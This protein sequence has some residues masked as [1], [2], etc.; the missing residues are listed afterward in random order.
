VE[1]E[2]PGIILAEYP[3]LSDFR[4][5]VTKDLNK[6]V[7]GKGKDEWYYYFHNTISCE[8]G[9]G[10]S[11]DS[12]P[13]PERCARVADLYDSIRAATGKIRAE[14]T[15][16]YNQKCEA[17]QIILSD[18]YQGFDSSDYELTA[19]ASG[20]SYVTSARSHGY[21][22]SIEDSRGTTYVYERGTGAGAG[23]RIWMTSTQKADKDYLEWAAKQEKQ[24]QKQA[25]TSGSASASS[26]AAAGKTQNSG[27]SGKTQNSGSG[28]NSSSKK[29]TV[30]DQDSYDAG[31]EDVYLDYDYDEERYRT[32]DDYARGVD[33]AMDDEGWDW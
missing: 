5:S 28:K 7:F 29:K 26:G 20:I 31:Y 19:N 4:A 32:D 24:S 15:P 10:A 6:H 30:Y 17:S 13:D 23:K 8:A 16:F 2:L 3:E 12:L 33:D 14:K 11:F 9:M 27:N 21:L 1:A 25:G 18:D 22:D